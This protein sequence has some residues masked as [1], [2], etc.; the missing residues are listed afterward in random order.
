[1]KKKLLL[2]NKDKKRSKYD[3]RMLSYQTYS[4]ER[5]SGHDRRFSG[6]KLFA[7]TENVRLSRQG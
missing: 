4:P 3:R 2:L 7:L 6:Y 5:R 1:M